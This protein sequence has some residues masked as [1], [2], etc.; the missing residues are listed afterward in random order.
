MMSLSAAG[1]SQP[2]YPL[3]SQCRVMSGIAEKLATGMSFYLGGGDFNCSLATQTAHKSSPMMRAMDCTQISCQDI[4]R[5]IRLKFSVMPC[6]T[7]PALRVAQNDS[8]GF[9]V[10]STLSK[11]QT[12]AV[13]LAGPVFLFVGI[14]QHANELSLGLQVHMTLNYS[15][16]ICIYVWCTGHFCEHYKECDDCSLHWNSLGQK[17]VPWM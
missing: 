16:H 1:S 5:R 10:N 11:S 17:R 12:V 2:W 15:C 3:L 6:S 9:V 4:S 7:P 13:D 8:H 14:R